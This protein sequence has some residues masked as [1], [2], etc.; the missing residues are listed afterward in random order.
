MSYDQLYVPGW[1]RPARHRRDRRTDVLVVTLFMAGAIG[2]LLGF[3][4][5]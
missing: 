1:R 5:L 2:G 3:V 4:A